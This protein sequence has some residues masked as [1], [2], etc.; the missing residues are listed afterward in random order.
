MSIKYICK[1]GSDRMFVKSSGNHIGLYC[2]ECGKWIKWLSKD[3]SRVFDPKP[4]TNFDRIKAKSIE[5]M[6]A[7][8]FNGSICDKCVRR[9]CSGT[10]DF[11]NECHDGI[12]KW[13]KQ[14]I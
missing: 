8:I 12:I 6:A 4:R 5:E 11:E 9:G 1:C 14:N 7:F 13:L 10:Y 3:E 2:K